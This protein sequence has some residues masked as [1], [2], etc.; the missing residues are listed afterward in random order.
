MSNVQ[1]FS[2]T[3]S[4]SILATAKSLLQSELTREHAHKVIRS[5]ERLGAN[6]GPPIAG[7]FNVPASIDK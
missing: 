4:N 5:S 6:P 1:P 7:L 2:G 3:A